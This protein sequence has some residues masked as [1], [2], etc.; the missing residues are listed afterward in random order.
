MICYYVKSILL[1]VAT[2]AI[3][4]NALVFH[5]HATRGTSNEN[6]C[7]KSTSRRNILNQGIIAL[8]SLTFIDPKDAAFAE[9]STTQQPF[10][11][12]LSVQTDRDS[13]ETKDVEIEVRP[14]WAPLAAARF[15][16]LVEIGFYDGS[17]FHRVLPLYV[18]QFGIAPDPKLNKEWMFCERNCKSLPDEPRMVSN[19]KGTLSFASSGKNSRQ[20]QVFV[21]LVDNDGVPNF[22]DAQGFVPFARVVDINDKNW[23]VIEK[24]NKEYGIKESV[25]GGILGSVSQGKSAYYGAE[26][27]DALFP[28]LSQIK[29]AKLM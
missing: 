4:T 24:L 26:Y 15:K 11:V 22:L 20:T 14:D 3:N 9:D 21:N 29:S 8:S 18:A 28:R 5:S 17:R 13:D 7:E 16:E 10:N 2:A 6:R 25:S 12:I 27:L 23:A 19:K 1:L